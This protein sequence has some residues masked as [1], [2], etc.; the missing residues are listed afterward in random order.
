MVE[1]KYY[2][3]GYDDGLA[4]IFDEDFNRI[5]VG[6]HSKSKLKSFGISFDRP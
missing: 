4:I 6:S 1:N 3:F 2:R 5:S